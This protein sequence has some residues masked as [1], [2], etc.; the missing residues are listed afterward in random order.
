MLDRDNNNRKGAVARDVGLRA[1]RAS[2]TSISNF[3]DE[4]E[5]NREELEEEIQ[6]GYHVVIVVVLGDILPQIAP[7]WYRLLEEE[8]SRPQGVEDVASPATAARRLH[9][10]NPHVYTRW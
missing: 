4:V 2:S 7:T 10:V 6:D 8:A 3:R 5:D 1:T 9:V